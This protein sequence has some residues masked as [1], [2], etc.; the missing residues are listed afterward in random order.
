MSHV[1]CP[2]FDCPKNDCSESDF[3]DLDCPKSDCPNA[4]KSHLSL[5]DLA[6]KMGLSRRHLQRMAAGGEVPG[7]SRSKS[8]H[9]RVK[10][11]LRLNGWITARSFDVIQRGSLGTKNTVPLLRAITKFE[12]SLKTATRPALDRTRCDVALIMQMKDYLVAT[13]KN[14]QGVLDDFDS[15]LEFI[16]KAQ[17][18]EKARRAKSLNG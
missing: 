16:D 15:V 13:Q 12:L 10:N 6:V 8:G 3:S 14:L 9:W 5:P 7:A 1:P 11:D 2:K 17:A 4:P 18:R